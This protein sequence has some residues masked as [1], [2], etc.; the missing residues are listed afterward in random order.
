MEMGVNV[1][2]MRV[3]GRESSVWGGGDIYMG[4]LSGGS[5]GGGLWT[6]RRRHH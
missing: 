6:I 3:G 2:Q 4:H 5:G 1:I